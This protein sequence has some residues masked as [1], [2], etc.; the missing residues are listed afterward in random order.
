MQRDPFRLKKCYYF[1]SFA[2]TV[3]ISIQR[4]IEIR[5]RPRGTAPERVLAR[6]FVELET[7]AIRAAQAKKEMARKIIALAEEQLNLCEQDE[8][9]SMKKIEVVNQIEVSR[10][11]ILKLEYG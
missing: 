11:F 2:V 3:C 7:K 4:S 6:Q 8:H 10:S 9:L 5:R 1:R